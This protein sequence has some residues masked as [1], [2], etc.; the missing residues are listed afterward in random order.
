M[1]SSEKLVLNILGFTRT[2]IRPFAYAMDI[3]V[4][5]LFKQKI[6]KTN[7]KI[8]KDIYPVVAQKLHKSSHAVAKSA[9]RI[10]A[11]CWDTARRNNLIVELFGRPLIETPA[12]HDILFYLAVLLYF[13]KPFFTV[14][15]DLDDL[16]FSA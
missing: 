13:G 9:Q 4:D 8:T 1:L 14:L 11:L 5:L 6:S 12:T 16:N 10:A 7:I 2:D 3:V 15:Q